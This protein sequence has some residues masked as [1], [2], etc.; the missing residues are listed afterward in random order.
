VTI[1]ESL[2]N[3][4]IVAGRTVELEI[5]NASLSNTRFGQGHSVLILGEPG[6]G[7]STLVAEFIR[8][9]K[10]LNVHVLT[11]SAEEGTVQPFG[12]FSRALAPVIDRKLFQEEEYT[13]FCSI[14]L[15]SN[16]GM[17]LAQSSFENE[18]M[19][20]DIF[21]GMLSAVQN[22]VKDSFD[23]SGQQ[24]GG[25]GKIVYGDMTVFMEHG[26]NIFLA[27][28]T[29]GI[30]HS[31]MRSALTDAARN[32]EQHH[33]SVFANW[34]GNMEELAA[35]QESI[36]ELA[37]AKFL[38]KRGVEGVKFENER[39]RM[40]EHVAN[41]LAALS[42]K[43]PTIILIEDIHWAD[44][45]SMFLFS[46]L[47]RNIS[48]ERIL[49]LA[50]A[51]PGDLAAFNK[52][53]EGLKE[54]GL[55]MDMDLGGLDEAGIAKLLNE[56][57]SPNEFPASFTKRLAEDSKGNPLFIRETLNQ[58]IVE[59][60][61][62][63]EHG[64]YYLAREDY[65]FPNSLEGVVMRR[66]E[67]LS[68][69]AITLAEYGSCV[70]MDFTRSDIASLPIIDAPE[71]TTQK[72]IQAGIISP[73]D[74][75]S[76][77]SHAMFQHT[78]YH[79]ISERWK[80]I[81]HKNIG[82]HYERTYG[83][84][85]DSVMY[86][87]ARHFSNC[88]EHQKAFDYC[89]RAGDKAESSFAAELAMN[90]YSNALDR[91]PQLKNR[92]LNHE[93]EASILEKLA[94]SQR[95]L[96]LIHQ[97][98]ENYQRAL[99][100]ADG[101]E[102]TILEILM[103][104]NAGYGILN[105]ADRGF[106]FLEHGLPLVELASPDR[107][108]EFLARIG[109]M[110]ASKNRNDDARKFIAG[111]LGKLED[112]RDVGTRVNVFTLLGRLYD[113][114]GPDKMAL[115]M[116]Q[117]AVDEAEKIGNLKSLAQAYTAIGMYMHFR[118]EH[119]SAA[120][121][122]EKS[123]AYWEKLGDIVEIQRDL[124]SL[125]MAYSDFGELDKSLASLK[126]ALALNRKL[127]SKLNMA[128]TLG[129]IGYTLAMMGRQEESLQYQTEAL[130]IRKKQNSPGGMG[131]SHF[132]M[133]L[134]HLQMGNYEMAK[135]NLIRAGD[136]FKQS[137]EDI[138]LA[139]AKLG[140]AEFFFII[141]ETKMASQ[142]YREALEVAREKSAAHSMF[143]ALK[144]LVETGEMEL[145]YA[146]PELESLAKKLGSPMIIIEL[147]EL[148]GMEALR[149]KNF[150]ESRNFLETALGLATEAKSIDGEMMAANLKLSMAKL[151][152]AMGDRE[153]AKTLAGESADMFRSRGRIGKARQA[154]VFIQSL[155]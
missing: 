145:G 119:Q 33:R 49:M 19:D 131:W 147:L 42:R 61:I 123:V 153:N 99:V 68:P 72:L 98:L 48:Q 3:L 101:K 65:D 71:A 115:Q 27:A 55:L 90:F 38:V 52:Y 126:R 87:L 92:T 136:L 14:F 88:S 102:N 149:S 2:S 80:A 146:L 18:S 7:K 138:G 106:E 96:G 118:G 74:R 104:I 60:G 120:K 151:H 22:F 10:T 12:V 155:E 105:E 144:G 139:L 73:T 16:S 9:A 6:I 32:L 20:A 116:Y 89:M 121:L 83:S 117:F 54:D 111:A 70:G 107:S 93:V 64:A 44:D 11:G 97:S 26:Q 154:E 50:T 150:D 35:I 103:K 79:S 66:L 133:S 85:L 36:D 122:F 46:Y 112:V 30:E 57:F 58:M 59:S 34:T 15:I 25:L 45:S 43:E 41:D 51:R 114:I 82:E 91:L 5:L 78:L 23:S 1:K 109:L 125:G 13:G 142:Q 140:L 29:K 28:V 21:A 69:E 113:K 24:T 47:T 95:R 37:R 132:D 81:Y 110:N 17:L 53:S 124:V 141:G 84:N 40:A 148:R 76:R 31:S 63:M 130:E 67:T 4:S 135:E 86:E 56:S 100:F 39:L 108:S 134:V 77:F 62:S 129:N 127:G 128:S 94:D 8:H 75:G 143:S 152:L 137:R